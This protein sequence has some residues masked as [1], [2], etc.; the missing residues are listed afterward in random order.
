MQTHPNRIEV[1]GVW[2]RRMFALDKAAAITA[3]SSWR[4]AAVAAGGVI[5]VADHSIGDITPFLNSGL[6]TTWM[7]TMKLTVQAAAG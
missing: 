6:P 4:S 1:L 2:R 3:K 5:D 7:R